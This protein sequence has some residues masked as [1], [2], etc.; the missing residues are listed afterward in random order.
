MPASTAEG[1]AEAAYARMVEADLL[2][3]YLAHLAHGLLGQTGFRLLNAPTFL[4]AYVL[5]L[6]GGSNMAVGV[7]LSLQAF[8]MVLTPMLGATL[9]EHRSRVLPM[10]FVTGG[11]MRIMVLLIAVAGLVFEP[12]WALV[13]IGVFVLGFGLFMGMQGVIFNFLMSKVIPVSKRGRLTGLRN[14]LA[15]LTSAGVAWFGGEYLLGETPTIVGYSWTFMMAFVLT[16]VGLATLVF[17]REPEPPSLRVRTPFGRRLRELPRF[18][19]EDPAFAR[20]V[21]ARALATM[22]R[23]AAPFYILYA[24]QEIGLTGTTLGVLTVAFT[25]SG[26]FSNLVWGALADRYGFRLTFL[27][28]MALW[29]LSTVLLMFSGGLLFTAL[30][31]VG[32]GAAFQGFQQSSMNLTLEFGHRDD[33]PM[34]IALAN[35]ASELAGTIGPLLGGALAAALGYVAVF[36]ASI[37]FLVVGSVL[38]LRF[39]PE[40]RASLDRARAV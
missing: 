32:I 29:I 23:M 5:L 10:G 20:Y 11:L 33:L 28:S 13:A 26:T 6:S 8:G 27:A 36:H 30:V 40:P 34:R 35:T 21:A 9:I 1:D 12:D 16:S 17:V 39:V 4:P 22:G 38:I 31:F 7:V 3:N 37:L 25:L 15:G 14:F 2:R 19:R 24:G 18:M